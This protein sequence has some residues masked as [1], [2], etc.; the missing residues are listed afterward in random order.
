M[1]NVG[2]TAAVTAAAL[3][4]A[5]SATAR[6]VINQTER[7]ALRRLAAEFE[8]SRKAVADGGKLEQEVLIL[9]TWT[10]WYVNAVRSIRDLEAGGPGPGTTTAIEAAAAAIHGA[11]LNYV[12]RLR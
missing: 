6:F 2:V 11:G 9:T 12:A 8:L 10:E 1:T 5:D 4:T 7:A 3:V